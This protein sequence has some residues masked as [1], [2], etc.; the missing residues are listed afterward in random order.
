MNAGDNG[1][2]NIPSHRITDKHNSSVSDSE[3]QQDGTVPKWGIG[4]VPENWG[5]AMN[6]WKLQE[7]RWDIKNEI[8]Q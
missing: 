1:Y 7:V 6:W 5:P 3:S 8:F 4:R 2:L